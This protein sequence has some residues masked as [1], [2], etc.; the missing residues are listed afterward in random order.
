MDN[1]QFEKDL[2]ADELFLLNDIQQEE[3]VNEDI[4]QHGESEDESFLV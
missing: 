2:V 3:I 1:T 4:S